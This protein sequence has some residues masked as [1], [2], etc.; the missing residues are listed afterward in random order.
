M[1]KNIVNLKSTPELDSGVNPYPPFCRL[2]N[3]MF[4]FAK[5]LLD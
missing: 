2:I 5:I 4:F 1:Q 3:F